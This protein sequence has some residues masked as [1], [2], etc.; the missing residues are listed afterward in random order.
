VLAQRE[1]DLHWID[2]ETQAFLDRLVASLPAARLLVLGSYRPEYAHAW[3]SK[4]YYTQKQRDPVHL[5]RIDEAI[6]FRVDPVRPLLTSAAYEALLD[7]V[8]RSYV[9]V[10]P[11]YDMGLVATRHEG[12]AKSALVSQHVRPP[13]P[14]RTRTKVCRPR[15]N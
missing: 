13:Q 10:A 1:E 4:C 9:L 5:P 8:G 7:K 15:S 2:A 3:A 14:R 12:Q 11:A 6:S